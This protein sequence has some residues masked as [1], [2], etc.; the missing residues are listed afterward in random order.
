MIERECEIK[1]P[2]GMHARPATLFVEQANK[3]RCSISVRKGDIE[4]NGKSILGVMMLCAGIGESIIITARG[5]SLED[6]E[7]II[8][9]LSNL[10]DNKFYEEESA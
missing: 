10:I 6:E 3:S 1:N 2:S 4:V 7:K 5:E 9:D 8:N